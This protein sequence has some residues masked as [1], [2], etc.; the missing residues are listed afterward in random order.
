[1]LTASPYSC[2]IIAVDNDDDDRDDDDDGNDDGD[3]DDDKDD[4]DKDDDDKDDDDDDGTDHND[5]N[6]VFLNQLHQ[7]FHNLSS[8]R[9][10]SN[11]PKRN[12]YKK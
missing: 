3:N 12:K 10:Y 9:F 5:N 7:V 2:L 11:Q 8:K 6:D 1:M 4:N